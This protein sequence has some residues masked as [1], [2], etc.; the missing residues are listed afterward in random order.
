L[1]QDKK[2]THKK[3]VDTFELKSE[4]YLAESIKKLK[5][6]ENPLQR[7]NRIHFFLKCFLSAH[8]G[9]KREEIEGC[10][11]LFSFVIIRL[12]RSWKK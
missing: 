3:I 8:T 10:I 12:R 4:T 7:V 6:S 11:N 9:F 1:I 5:N 2:K